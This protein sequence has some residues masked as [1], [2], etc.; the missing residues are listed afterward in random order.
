VALA[1]YRSGQRLHDAYYGEDYDYTRKDNIREAFILFPEEA[2][3]WVHD[4]EMLW[5]AVELRERRK[6]S[7]VAREY[8]VALPRELDAEG[9][10]RLVVAWVQERFV[11][12]GL[13]AD[14][15]IHEGTERSNPHAH[16]ML[17]T[18][19]IDERGFGK[20]VTDWSNE[21]QR[22]IED[23]ESWARATNLELAREG[24]SARID[25]RTLEAQGIR[26]EPG[27]HL[28]PKLSREAKY[29]ER[30]LAAIRRTREVELGR[31]IQSEIRRGGRTI[32]GDPRRVTQGAGIDHDQTRSVSEGLDRGQTR[33]VREHPIE[34]NLGG[35]ARELGKVEKAVRR[36]T[37][38]S[39]GVSGQ[40]HR[41]SRG[42]DLERQLEDGELKK[43]KRINRKNDEERKRKHGPHLHL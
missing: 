38:G 23:R 34:T 13:V 28:G 17:P 18:R 29:L 30:E 7:Q 33:G 12:R 4:R 11:G 40:S 16:V 32:G 5:N 2:P 31:G 39:E 15:A 6:D 19:E 24:I 10:R 35:V 8:N 3:E 9:Q 36:I 42:D 41:P 20:K 26:R 43:R 27:R 14:V 1:A 21:R 22:L 25:H 37:E